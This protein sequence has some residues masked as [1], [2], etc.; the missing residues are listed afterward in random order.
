VAI[1]VS[2]NNGDILGLIPKTPIFH[3]N[4]RGLEAPPARTIGSD[5]MIAL[6]AVIEERIASDLKISDLAA[7]AGTSTHHFCRRFK[8][9]IGVSPYACVTSIRM[10]WARWLISD[11]AM[12][13]DDISHRVGSSSVSYFRKQF[14]KRFREV[15]SNLRNEHDKCRSSMPPDRG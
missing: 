12:S 10:L 5:K 1:A 3:P 2:K 4:E 11:T 8:M 14:Y 7:V 6:V 15:P 9:T 13:V